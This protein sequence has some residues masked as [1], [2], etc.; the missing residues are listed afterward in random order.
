MTPPAGH[1][2]VVLLSVTFINVLLISYFCGTNTVVSNTIIFGLPVKY[3]SICVSTFLF[4]TRFK[5]KDFFLQVATMQCFEVILIHSDPNVQKWLG[6][7]NLTLFFYILY[8][9]TTVSL[10]TFVRVCCH[11]RRW[12][13]GISGFADQRVTMTRGQSLIASAYV[14]N[15]IQ[16]R[17]LLLSLR[18]S[19]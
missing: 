11:I 16:K 14:I 2:H 19:S 13:T 10:I 17:Y 7:I 5:L 9:P 4:W 18:S 3:Y 6:F 12:G 1:V 15:T 8:K